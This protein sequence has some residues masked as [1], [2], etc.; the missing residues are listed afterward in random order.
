MSRGTH[1]EA[2]FDAVFVV[3]SS[4][5][6]SAYCGFGHVHTRG[7]PVVFPKSFHDISVRTPNIQNRSYIRIFYEL[8]NKRDSMSVSCP[9]VIAPL[10]IKQFIDAV[11]EHLLLTHKKS[12]FVFACDGAAAEI[13][14]AYV[15]CAR[16]RSTVD[17]SFGGL[18]SADREVA[19]C[20]IF[21]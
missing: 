18:E 15:C 4:S 8:V 16:R 7:N 10:A 13:R 3:S 5:I 11:V 2:F 6:C 14:H 20:H 21:F 9:D 19:V 12:D 17:A 1:L